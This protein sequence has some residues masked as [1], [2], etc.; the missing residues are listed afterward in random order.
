MPAL[1]AE[2]PLHLTVTAATPVIVSNGGMAL[3]APMVAQFRPGVGGTLTVEHQIADATEWTAWPFGAV[4]TK[5][6]KILR[7]RVRALRFTAAVSTGNVELS[8]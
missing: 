8:A 1:I 6:L 2:K 3:P 4:S 5:Q 7:C